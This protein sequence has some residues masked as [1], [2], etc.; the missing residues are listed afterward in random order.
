VSARADKRLLGRQA[1]GVQRCGNGWL[2]LVRK[3]GSGLAGCAARDERGVAAG[4]RGIMRGMMDG[5][6]GRKGGRVAEA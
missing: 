3:E 1:G 2:Q 5:W 6:E 4:V